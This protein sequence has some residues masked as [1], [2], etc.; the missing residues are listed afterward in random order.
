MKISEHTVSAL[1]SIITGDGN[2]SPY[3]SGPQ[4]IS[5]FGQFGSKDEYGDGFPSRWYYAECKLREYNDS[6]SMKEIVLSA[7]DPRPYL[8]SEH[9]CE[10]AIEHLNQFL[11]Y[12][13]FRVQQVG[14]NL[15]VINLDEHQ[16]D[17][18]LP[19]G[20]PA[21]VTHMFI[22]EQISKCKSK[23]SA[24]DFDGAITNARSLVEAVLVSIE[25]EFDVDAPDYDGNLPKLYRRV[26]RHLNLVPGQEGLS[27][28]LRQI[29]SGL[30]SLVSGLSSLRNR[31]G[32]SHVTQYKAGEHHARL[33]VNSAMTFCD[34]I[35]R[36]KE[37]QS[38]RN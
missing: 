19:Y 27:D 1:G 24:E 20:E 10:A 35:Y 25:R 7:V 33:A 21:E 22:G 5:F 29:L 36:T 23:L 15:N 13:G 11:V 12:D 26:Q 14:R 37:Y 38:S 3:R 4:L 9:Q 31:M 28:N 2:L 17:V 8:S 16:I 32:D 34:F 18:Q 6:E 30:T